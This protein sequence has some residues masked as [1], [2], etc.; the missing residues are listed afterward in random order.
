LMVCHP[1]RDCLGC[2]ESA[3]YTAGTPLPHWQKAFKEPKGLKNRKKGPKKSLNVKKITK[4]PK[5]S[6]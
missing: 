4:G 3:S 1:S 6:K 2:R 5:E